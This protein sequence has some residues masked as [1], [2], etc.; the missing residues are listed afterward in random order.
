MSAEE[1]ALDLGISVS[2]VNRDIAECIDRTNAKE[3]I[4]TED[5][6]NRQVAGKRQIQL[7]CLRAYER[8]KK[9]VVRTEVIE[10]DAHGKTVKTVRMTQAGN[11]AFLSTY[12]QADAQIEDL[13]GLHRKERFE[14]TNQGDEPT[15]LVFVEL[16]SREDKEEFDAMLTFNEAKRRG[17]LDGKATEHKSNGNGSHNGNGHHP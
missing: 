3:G 16:E 4:R 8:S 9:D 14:D 10:S 6:V 11:P 13:H 5:L 2:T 12:L 17:I 15:G 7:E 1:I